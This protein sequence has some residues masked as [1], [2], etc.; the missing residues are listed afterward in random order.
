MSFVV[1]G[2]YRGLFKIKF[3]SESPVRPTGD[4]LIGTNSSSAFACESPDL[5]SMYKHLS[6]CNTAIERRTER[7]AFPP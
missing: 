7:I 3:L 4:K 5:Q 2:A 6:T 1:L